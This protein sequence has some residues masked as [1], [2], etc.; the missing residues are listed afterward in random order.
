MKKYIFLSVIV[1]IAA[2]LCYVF[3]GSKDETSKHVLR[4]GV[5]CDYAP[6]NWEEKTPTDFNVPLSNFKGL[7]AEGYDI[8]IA[9]LVADK[10]DADLEVKKIAWEN[11]I[12][13]LQN[14]EIDAIFSGMLDTNERKKLAAFTEPYEVK[15]TE[16]AVV[17]NKNSPYAGAKKLTDFHGAKFTG[18]KD[19]NLYAS[20]SQ[21]P[22]AIAEPAVDT[23][24][25]ML[26]A[27]IS[28]RVDGIVINL[29][30]G[31]SYEASHKEL[32]LIHF[33]EDEGF[34]IGF[35]GICAA[36]RKDDTE[37]LRRVNRIIDDLKRSERQKIM[38]GTV[39]R[40]LHGMS[41]M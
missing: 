25:E 27:V 40:L 28:G 18:Q 23:V 11:L 13:A 3:Q 39:T 21:L 6:N 20:I 35:T 29:D 34:V 10:L 1:V 5:E 32:K 9:K 41:N 14:G 8:Q 7:Y 24:P 26:D 16:Y 36:L 4:V 22:G 12:P 19:T 2:L 38:D 17:V 15:K 30:T 37:L 33:P 31:R